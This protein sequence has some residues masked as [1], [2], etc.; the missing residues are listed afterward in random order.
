MQ[1]LGN[2]LVGPLAIKPAEPPYPEPLFAR[3]IIICFTGEKKPQ[4]L[5]LFV[6][7]NINTYRPDKKY[8]RLQKADIFLATFV[9]FV[10]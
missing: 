8:F 9:I 3:R 1:R 10:D 6:T 7:D 5:N 2:I 4:L